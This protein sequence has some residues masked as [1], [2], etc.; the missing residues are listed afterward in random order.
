MTWNST[1][2]FG[3]NNMLCCSCYRSLS[4]TGS[5]TQCWL[6]EMRD[7]TEALLQIN[8]IRA[9]TDLEKKRNKVVEA[10]NAVW[11]WNARN[12]SASFYFIM[13]YWSCL[14]FAVPRHMCQAA[15]IHC[16]IACVQHGP[17][18][19]TWPRFVSSHS[20][21]KRPRLSL[22]NGNVHRTRSKIQQ[23]RKPK[24]WFAAKL[25]TVRY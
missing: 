6:K 25:I 19:A 18:A 11:K 10:E 12:M 24:I 7:C 22:S 17:A 13:T 5:Q 20:Y 4:C 8:V 16:D 23:G 3:S 9:L 2:R 1:T 15:G 14:N 21:D